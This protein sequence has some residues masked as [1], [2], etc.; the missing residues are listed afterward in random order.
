LNPIMTCIR[1]QIWF[2]NTFHNVW[3]C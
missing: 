3:V 2:R 1:A